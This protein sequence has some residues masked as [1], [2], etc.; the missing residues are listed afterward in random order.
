MAMHTQSALINFI[1]II[2][3]AN[4]ICQRLRSSI[5]IH[6]KI[7]GRSH[8]DPM[9]HLWGKLCVRLVVSKSKSLLPVCHIARQ[10]MI[11]SISRPLRNVNPS[12]CTILTLTIMLI[13]RLRLNLWPELRESTQQ[14]YLLESNRNVNAIINQWLYMINLNQF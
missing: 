10:F 8:K 14:L 11:D 6:S 2:I 4:S 5:K 3:W 13:L 9:N 1:N 7:A 12:S